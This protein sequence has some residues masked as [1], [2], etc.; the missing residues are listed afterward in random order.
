M[1]L[2]L[3]LGLDEECMIFGNMQEKGHEDQYKCTARDRFK[4]GQAAPSE[5]RIQGNSKGLEDEIA[6]CAEGVKIGICELKVRV[7]MG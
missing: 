3:K 1:N 4:K 5:M 6:K 2:G 7:K